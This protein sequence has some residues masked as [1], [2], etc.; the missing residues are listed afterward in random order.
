MCSEGWLLSK[1]TYWFVSPSWKS[2]GKRFPFF[3]TEFSVWIY[4]SDTLS[5]CIYKYHVEM[6]TCGKNK[7]DENLNGVLNILII[8]YK[9]VLFIFVTLT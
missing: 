3:I 5:D 6:Y 2:I 4:F 7:S 1:F 9:N 8:I